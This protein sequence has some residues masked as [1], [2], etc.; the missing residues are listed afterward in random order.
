[1]PTP[2]E[3]RRRLCLTI[4]LS[5]VNGIQSACRN[6]FVHRFQAIA[7]LFLLFIFPGQNRQHFSAENVQHLWIEAMFGMFTQISRAWDVKLYKWLQNPNEVPRIST[8]WCKCTPFRPHSSAF[9]RSISVFHWYV[10]FCC[11]YLFS[12]LYVILW[13]LSIHRILRI[14]W[15]SQGI[16]IYSANWYQLQFI[17]FNIDRV[18]D[19]SGVG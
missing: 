6:T 12:F 7:N 11:V 18:L 15:Q 16:D 17:Q 1:M 8:D 5:I 4:D 3:I 2:P 19:V 9:T 13:S 10:S 14:Q